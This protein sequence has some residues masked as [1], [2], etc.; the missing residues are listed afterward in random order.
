MTK[1]E[2]RK[3]KVVQDDVAGEDNKHSMAGLD[4]ESTSVSTS[5]GDRSMVEERLKT[6]ENSQQCGH[7]VVYAHM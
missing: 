7:N 5:F 2:L 1:I 3:R 6:R 4:A